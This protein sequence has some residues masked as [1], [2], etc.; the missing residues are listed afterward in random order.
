MSSHRVLLIDDDENIRESFA[1]LLEADGYEVDSAGTGEEGIAKSHERFYNMAIVDYR[2][3]DIMGTE[4]LGRLRE[5]R[6]KM[7]K[8]MVT[9]FP[10][11]SNAVEA[12]NRRADAFFIKPVDPGQLLGKVSDLL[13]EQEEERG[14]WE[15]KLGKLVEGNLVELKGNCGVNR[16][17]VMK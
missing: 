10:S 5:T 3:P 11:M 12:V 8:I 7:R 13:V 2:L 16:L 4:V 6:P 9:G 1:M 14:L 17:Q 15:L